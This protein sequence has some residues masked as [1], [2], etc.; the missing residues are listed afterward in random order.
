[1]SDKPGS[2]SLLERTETSTGGGYE[3]RTTFAEGYGRKST[4]SRAFTF[5]GDAIRQSM[6]QPFTGLT[7][8]LTEVGQRF[9][10]DAQFT[11]AVIKEYVK[12][13][14]S[15]IQ[16][17]VPLPPGFARKSEFWKILLLSGTVACF[18]GVAAAGFMNFVDEVNC[19]W[20]K[21]II[22]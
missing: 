5:D 18:M 1:M 8:T 9:D 12:H 20:L 10:P 2:K 21:H 17:D 16:G 11:K 22:F 4:F 7:R 15:G 19:S 6:A 13:A 3:T 14:E